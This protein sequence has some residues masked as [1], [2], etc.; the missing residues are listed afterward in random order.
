[1]DLINFNGF[2]FGSSEIRFESNPL[3][4]LV[5]SMSVVPSLIVALAKLSDVLQFD[6]T[7]I[8]NVGVGGIVIRFVNY[9][10]FDIR[11]IK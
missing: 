3:T 8:E 4:T 7:S 10:D 6:L 9:S 1:M 5:T 2:V 11:R